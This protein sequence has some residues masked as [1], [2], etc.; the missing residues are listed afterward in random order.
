MSGM[1]QDETGPAQEEHWYAVYTKKQKEHYADLKLLQLGIP[2]FLP[3]IRA[4]IRRR[5]QLRP[6]FPC[7][8]FAYFDVR[9]WLYAVNHL[10]GIHKVVSFNDNPIPV[11]PA[12][13]ESLKEEM[14][15]HGFMAPAKRPKPGDQVRIRGGL[16][17]G[18]EGRIESLRPKDRVVVLL[19][20]IISRARLEVDGDVLEILREYVP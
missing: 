15:T 18:Y 3:L 13:I 9:R 4:K 20:A 5:Y 12:I 7:Y 8:L 14:G 2:T 1:E 16:F 11:D 17:D 6:L 10:E 19:N